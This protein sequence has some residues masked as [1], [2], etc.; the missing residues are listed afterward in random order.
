MVIAAFWNVSYTCLVVWLAFLRS[1]RFGLV[2]CFFGSV[3]FGL[4]GRGR[5]RRDLPRV[6]IDTLL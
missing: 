6:A 2:K 3:R 5:A 4:R 1:I